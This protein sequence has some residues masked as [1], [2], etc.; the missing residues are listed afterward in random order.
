MLS[1]IWLTAS[2]NAINFDENV[3][4]WVPSACTYCCQLQVQPATGTSDVCCNTLG[5]SLTS[6]R[7]NVQIHINVIL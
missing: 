4:F 2:L 3:S 5:V 7:C 1:E 6:S